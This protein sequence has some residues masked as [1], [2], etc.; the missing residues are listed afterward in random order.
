MFSQRLKKKDNDELM[1]VGEPKFIPQRVDMIFLQKVMDFKKSKK[2]DHKPRINNQPPAINIQYGLPQKHFYREELEAHQKEYVQ[3]I[4]LIKQNVPQFKI[5]YLMGL[6]AF[7]HDHL[8]WNY[9]FGWYAY[10]LDNLIVVE[11]LG[12]ERAQKIIPMP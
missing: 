12:K 3:K 2:R 1:V 7:S 11:Q 5:R 8:V 6:E 10:V 9:V 4:E